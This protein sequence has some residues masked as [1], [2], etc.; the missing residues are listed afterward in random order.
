[1]NSNEPKPDASSSPPLS[2]SASAAAS[3][4]DSEPDQFCHADGRTNLAPSQQPLQVSMELALQASETKLKEVL[5]RA[6]AALSSYRVFTDFTWQCDYHSPGFERI[7]GYRWEEVLTEPNLLLSRVMPEDLETLVQPSREAIMAGETLTIEYR[8]LHREGTLRWI[9]STLSSRWDEAAHCWIVTTV[10]TDVTD[11]KQGE[12]A[13]RHAIE[14]EQQAIQRE[15][16]INAITQNIRQSLDLDYILTTTVEEVQ[17]FL[18][19]DRVVIYR[20]NSDWS[21]RIIAEALENEDFSIID[22]DLHHPC[23]QEALL[24]SYRQGRIDTIN[25][26]YEA[27]LEPCYFKFLSE[28]QIQAVLVVPILVMQD[29]WGLL[30]AHQCTS[31]R[32]W[33]QINWLLLQQ[34]STQLAIGIHQA[35]LHQQAQQQA[36]KEQ[37]LNQVTQ[38]IRNSLDLNTIFVTATSEIGRLLQVDRAEIVQYLPEQ[39][40]WLNVASYRRSS[41]LPDGLGLTVADADHRFA[42]QLKQRQIIQVNADDV[43]AESMRQACG[44]MG[45][46]AWLL[47][48]LQVGLSVWGSLSVNHN[49]CSWRWQGW[50]VE[51]VCTIADQLAMAIQQSELYQQVR[52]LNA[53]LEFQV[54]ER[55]S[56]LQQALLFEDLLKRITDKVRDSLDESQILQTAVQEL[57]VGL[58]IF[59][60]DAALFD[61]ERRTSTI[62]Y[63][64]IRSEVNSA[65]SLAVDLGEYPDIYDQIAQGHCVQFCLRS[66]PSPPVRADKHQYAILC[67]PLMDDRGILGDLWLFKPL[68]E[69]FNDLEVRLA[70]QVANQC[71]I[72]V[73]QSRLY[74]A[75]QAQVEELERL[76]RLKDDFLSTVSH[77]LRTPM[78]NIRLA[79]QML[80]I[81]LQRLQLPVLVAELEDV[82]RPSSLARYF[83]ILKEEC[84]R[85]IYLISNVLELT[86][87]D[88]A[89]EPLFMTPIDLRIL[90][91]H[92]VE[93]FE[94]RIY[95]QQQHLQIHLPAELPKLITD[96]SYLERI[97]A[98]LLTNACK[99]TPSEGTI[100][101]MAAITSET[102]DPSHPSGSDPFPAFRSTKVLYPDLVSQPAPCLQ[103][104]VSNT[105]VEIPASELDR[106]FDKFYRIPNHDPWKHGGT[107]LGLA[108]VKKWSER[109]GASIAVT[110]MQ[111][112]ATFMLQFSATALQVEPS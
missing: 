77:E 6:I 95:R 70:Q 101:V 71:A 54:Q 43:N 89:T 82:D 37:V 111:E 87:L 15:R 56:Q 42:A 108:L 60:C 44:Q 59:C 68:Q 21:G 63:E 86:R 1:M 12:L 74:Q 55:T 61:L 3:H 45:T 100:T 20:F 32:Q 31:P 53:N 109:L 81:G 69:S 25:N 29:L 2:L 110:S 11:R 46:G 23:F 102:P 22:R 96:L 88:A 28:L 105:G 50:E 93:P 106:I 27:D 107:G 48:P 17:Q 10:S 85:E 65:Q 97:L 19:V 62:C 36:R 4:P 84:D 103:I 9:S 76:N 94:D 79:T 58:D 24:Q 8:F 91:P 98:E 47:V 38:A 104:C 41:D 75:A 64:Y 73:R 66:L 5:D 99:Y 51:T 30:I 57:G 34:L 26:I 90:L 52:Q 35:E 78:S 92:I 33:Q 18:Q 112:Q 67:C 83:K 80:E 39:K 16:F 13:M 14:R 7:C 72:A 40:I 49:Q